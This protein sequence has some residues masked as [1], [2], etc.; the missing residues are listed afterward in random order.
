MIFRTGS[1][2]IVGRCDEDVLMII[3]EFIKNIL[4]T[5][6]K[7][8]CQKNIATLEKK[9]KSKKIRKKNILIVNV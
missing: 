5:E 7:K 8:I 2:L 6:Y 3:Y 9:D 1:V 4:S